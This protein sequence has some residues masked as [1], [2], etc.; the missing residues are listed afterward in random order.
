MRGFHLGDCSRRVGYDAINPKHYEHVSG[1]AT[2][3][4]NRLMTFDAGCAFKYVLRHQEKG[5]PLQDLTKARWYIADAVRNSDPIFNSDEDRNE[6]VVLLH[7][8]WEAEPD[9]AMRCFFRALM[10]LDLVVAG[11]VVDKMIEYES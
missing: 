5:N 6:A 2:I 4:V 7:V 9:A 8:M 3:E 1:V 11:E 10:Q